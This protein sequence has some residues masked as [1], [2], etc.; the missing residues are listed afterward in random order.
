LSNPR[1][2]AS[3]RRIIIGNI[4]FDDQPWAELVIE[5]ED[6]VEIP[7]GLWNYKFLAK[8]GTPSVMYEV[9]RNGQPTLPVKRRAK[10]K[11]TK[12]KV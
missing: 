4:G 7:E 2:L 12:R 1:I 11:A 10:R 5:R 9:M 6:A 8:D 3:M